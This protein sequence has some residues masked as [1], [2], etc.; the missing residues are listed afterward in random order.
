LVNSSEQ[1]LESQCHFRLP[2]VNAVM[3]FAPSLPLGPCA[4]RA[5]DL[6][7]K[8][9]VA[10]CF[11]RRASG[12]MANC[13]MPDLQEQASRD[14]RALPA[15]SCKRIAAAGRKSLTR[16]HEAGNIHRSRSFRRRREQVRC[17]IRYD[18]PLPSIFSSSTDSAC[19]VRPSGAVIVRADFGREMVSRSK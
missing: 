12:R 4:R 9:C 19:V 17:F 2:C 7:K 5:G 13:W 18:A 6:F 16:L 1:P 11:R 3:G 14:S 15:G 10:G 8:T